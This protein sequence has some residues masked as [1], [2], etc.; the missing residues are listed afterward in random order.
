MFVVTNVEDIIVTGNSPDEIRKTIDYFTTE[1]K[2][3]SVLREINRFIGIDLIQDRAKRTITLSQ[4]PYGSQIGA[5]HSKS[6]ENT[7]ERSHC[8]NETYF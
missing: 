8:S 5:K 6:D 2:K 3:I 7:N 1:F 4:S